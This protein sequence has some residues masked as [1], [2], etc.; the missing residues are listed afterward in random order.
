M[1][2]DSKNASI[3][4]RGFPEP[5]ISPDRKAHRADPA[6][7]C[8]VAAENHRYGIKWTVYQSQPVRHDRSEPCYRV[9]GSFE[10]DPGTQFGVS[11]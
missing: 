10:K 8:P 2:P 4:P 3:H 5:D 9:I 7:A 6:A 11:E 1:L